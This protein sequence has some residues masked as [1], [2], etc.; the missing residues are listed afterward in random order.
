M[1]EN[2][3]NFM[4]GSKNW[5]VGII[6]I[7]VVSGIVYNTHDKYN[8]IYDSST[9]NV[10][11]GKAI[12]ALALTLLEDEIDEDIEQ[13]EEQE[14]IESKN[15]VE[16]KEEVIVVDKVVVVEKEEVKVEDEVVEEKVES[17]STDV[18]STFTGIMSVYSADCAGCSGY[19]GCSPYPYV[20][21]GNINYNDST[22]GSVRIVA[23]DRSIPCGTIM[24]VKSSKL[25]EEI[26]AIV[27]DRG[28]SVGFDNKVQLDLLMDSSVSNL[29]AFGL[30]YNMSA[31]IIR[32]GW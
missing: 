20:G 2:I 23:A 9:S 12:T 31:E 13:L 22:Y 5:V 15:E 7:L 17:S 3:S 11:L 24:K 8:D 21:N 10:N 26:Y 18:I 25:G 6:T 32:Y 30:D 27:L 19:V 16:I 14:D 4:K 28:G 1:K 29:S